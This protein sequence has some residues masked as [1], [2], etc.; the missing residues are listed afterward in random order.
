MITAGKKSEVCW[1]KGNWIILDIGFSSKKKTCGFAF[2]DESPRSLRYG[3]ARSAIVDR[4]RGQNGLIN[5]VIEAPLS[6]CFDTNGNPKGRKIEK[7]NSKTR[8]WYTGL[9]CLVMTAALYLIRDIHETTKDFPNIEVRLFEGFVSFK[10]GANDDKKDVHALRERIKHAQQD[11][12]SIC[13]FDELKL[14]E[15][16]EICSAFSVAGMD[17]GVPAVIIA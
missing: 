2:D 11:P 7:K 15:S 14:F 13:D 16:D 17:C 10:E 12:N 5:L 1:G 6:V 3:E 9:G 4:V 8:Y